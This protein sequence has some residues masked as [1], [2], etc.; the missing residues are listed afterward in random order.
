MAST[1][2]VLIVLL[3]LFVPIG[4][5]A[6]ARLTAA[7]IEGTVT[8]ESGAVLPGV[9]ITATNTAT[10]QTRSVVTGKD[11]RYYIGALQPGTYTLSAEL[12]GFVLQKDH[13]VRVRVGQ[14]TGVD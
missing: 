11:G 7:D 13:R 3:L 2:R 14:R 8:D 12:A 9:T 6:Q 4:L 10:N 5:F 1:T